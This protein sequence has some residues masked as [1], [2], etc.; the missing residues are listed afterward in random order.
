L[1]LLAGIDPPWTLTGGAALAGFHLHHRGT[2]DLDL[3]WHGQERLG[4]CKDEIVR[5]IRAAGLQVES[6]QSSD[7]FQ[8][9]RVSDGREAILV[10]LVAEP[11]LPVEPAVE[12]PQGSVRIRVDTP[13]E[14]LVNKICTL[15]GRAEFRDLVDVRALLAAGGDLAR[16]LRDAPR[17]DGG[18]S[19]LTLA[20]ILRGLPVAAMAR[21]E[22]VGSAETHELEGFRD[23][24]VARLTAAARPER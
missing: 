7:G 17:K 21:E 11:M 18:F 5:R 19:P 10:D 1:E 14:I 20:W 15:L 9:L 6:L 12:F 24:L 2:R 16:A 8:R 23:E 3:F 22:G 13:H 4:G